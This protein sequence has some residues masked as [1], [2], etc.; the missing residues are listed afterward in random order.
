MKAIGTVAAALE[1]RVDIVKITRCSNTG[2]K[3]ADSLSKAD[4]RYFRDEAEKEDWQL[5]T[6]PAW[7][8]TSILAWIA[9]LTARTP[10][11]TSRCWL[12]ATAGNEEG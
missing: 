9:E 1:C 10:L 7:V 12:A 5:D 4:F 2:A 6:A 8:P 3:L 11:L